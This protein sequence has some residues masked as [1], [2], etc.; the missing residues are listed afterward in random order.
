MPEIY[1]KA[2]EVEIRV[3]TME[4]DAKNV[5][6][7]RDNGAGFDMTYAH[8]LFRGL[9]AAALGHGVQRLWH[10]ACYGS[11]SYSAAQWACVG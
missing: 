4:L 11:K 1:R 6:F 9:S 2:V 3:G 8:K 7:V 10:W 5:Y